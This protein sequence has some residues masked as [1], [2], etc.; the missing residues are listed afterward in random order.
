MSAILP[1]T[2]PG[3]SRNDVRETVKELC[4]Y[5]RPLQ[6][7]VDFQLSQSGKREGKIA[8]R[9]ESLEKRCEELLRRMEALEEKQSNG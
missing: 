5:L 8:Q 7:N 1:G 3:I 4:S 9:L 2:P 6:E